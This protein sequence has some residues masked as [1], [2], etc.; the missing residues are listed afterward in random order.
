MMCQWDQAMGILPP[1]L[2]SEVNEV[3]KACLQ[4]LRLRIN[5][6]PELNFGSERIFLNRIVRR[7]DLLFCVNTASRY[8]PW[9]AETMARGF[10]T[11]QGGHRLGLC[12]E[13]VC[14]NGTVTGIREVRSINLRIA[15]DFPGIASGIRPR[16]SVLIVGPP[17]WGKTTL[18]R[19]LS[20]HLGKTET[21]CV[22]DERG[23]I[24]PEGME[25][26]LHTDI[27]TG[28]GKDQGIDM[29]LR[30]MSPDWIVVDE[31]TNPEDTRALIRAVGCGVRLLATAHGKS[32]EDLRRRRSYIPLI[33]QNIFHTFLFMNPDKSFRTERIA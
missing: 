3:G 1:W 25:T 7:E 22:V 31:I 13:A 2:R 17:G 9:A 4:E 10:L 32:P 27:L 16:G 20:R 26:G 5:A 8:S 23:E 21:V 15:R 12:G 33:E 24:F 19:D 30:T 6:P 28:C 11:I 29:V 18:L 14:H